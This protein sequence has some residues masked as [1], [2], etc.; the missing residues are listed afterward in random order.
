MTPVKVLEVAQASRYPVS[1]AGDGWMFAASLFCVVAITCLLT[2][3]L[4]ATLRQLWLDRK[5]KGREAV[6]SF[7]T[8]IVLICLS[9][10][11]ARAR[12]AAYKI[13]FGEASPETLLMILQIK[14][15][16]NTVAFWLVMSWLF[17]HTLFEP[18][19]TLKLSHPQSQVWGKSW[20]QIGR[21]AGVVGLSAVLAGAIALYKAFG[22]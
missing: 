9:G 6:M 4:F 19:W 8:M 21:F 17:I 3:R 5:I 15:W 2:M 12:E 7:R 1:S 13:G 20:F 18:V 16:A 11:A 22:G 10:L 14:E